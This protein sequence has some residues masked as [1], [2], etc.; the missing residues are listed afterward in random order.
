MNNVILHI[1]I[2]KTAT[3]FFQKRIWPNLK[4][5]TLLTRPYTQH[6]Y[7]FN[8]LQYADDSLYKKE[9]MVEEIK[10]IGAE[11]LLIS[12]EALSGKV[13]YFSYLNRSIIAR[14]LK[15]IFPKSKLI[16]FIRDQ[17]DILISHYSTY[18]KNPYG[19][20]RINELF[21]KPERNFSYDDYISTPGLYDLQTLYF[22]TNDYFIHLDCFLYAPM[23]KM[24]FEIFQDVEVILYE[25]FK[26]DKIQVI[27]KIENIIGEKILLDKININQRENKKLSYRDIEIKRNIN[28]YLKFTKN[29]TIVKMGKIINKLS[30]EKNSNADMQEYI[31]Q[32]VGNY[33]T[34]DNK[35]L[36]SMLPKINW[37]KFKNKYC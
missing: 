20:K 13:I 4:T 1:G 23:L 30:V 14:R 29:K 2:H 12:D 24:Y 21:W 34:E 26:K 31:E 5:Y 16:I 35:E 3:T 8:K 11:K 15:E 36:K 33:Y 19:T 7:A 28:R 27:N 17:K 32:Y 25:E 37:N 6:N 18:I 9:M 10:N 22:N